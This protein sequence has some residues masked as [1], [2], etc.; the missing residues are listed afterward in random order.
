MAPSSKVY[1]S[2]GV[3]WNNLENLISSS[4]LTDTD[5]SFY[6]AASNAGK[7]ETIGTEVTLKAVL[8]GEDFHIDLSLTYQDA[9][10]KQAEFVGIDLGYA[11]KILGYLKAYYDFK[12]GLSFGVTGR[13]VDKMLTSW[14]L[15]SGARLGAAADSY[16]LVGLNLRW[17][18]IFENVYLNVNV[19]NAFD[20]E[21]RYPCT[22]INNGWADQGFIGKGRTIL[23]TLGYKF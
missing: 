7:V 11:P 18:N 23:V 5:G 21:I 12:S 15:A 16:L 4:Y 22:S 13:Y 2:I 6:L 19:F 10:N 20:Q 17:E 14:D 8:P 1:A 9:K 3:F